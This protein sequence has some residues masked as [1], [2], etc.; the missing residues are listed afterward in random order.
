MRS[1][2][3][4]VTRVQ[5][6]LNRILSRIDTQIPQDRYTKLGHPK[7]NILIVNF[8]VNFGRYN[9]ILIYLTLQLRTNDP[10]TLNLTV[11][12]KLKV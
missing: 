12:I 1:G 10:I 4:S 5:G 9:A 7:Y 3:R 6:Q 11:K 8:H 2:D